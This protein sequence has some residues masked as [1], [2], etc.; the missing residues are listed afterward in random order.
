MLA[1]FIIALLV[2]TVNSDVLHFDQM[3]W[4]DYKDTPQGYILQSLDTF[5][6]A[7]PWFIFY[8]GIKF[9]EKAIQNERDK[10]EAQM[11]LK[12]AELENLKN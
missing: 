9:A 6:F 1:N 2:Q 12:I 5:R 3:F 11:Q 8:H 4:K 10:S 7:M